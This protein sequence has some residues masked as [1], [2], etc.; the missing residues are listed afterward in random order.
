M[1]AVESVEY[2][3]VENMKTYPL[4]TEKVQVWYYSFVRMQR[5]GS[6]ETNLKYFKG[7]E[8]MKSCD[9]LKFNLDSTSLAELVPGSMD[10][11]NNYKVEGDIKEETLSDCDKTFD[12]KKTNDFSLSMYYEQIDSFLSK[13]PSLFVQDG[14]LG[15]SERSCVHIRSVT[16]DPLVSLVLQSLTVS[17][18][19]TCYSQFPVLDV[20]SKEG[21]EYRNNMT[22]YF[23]KNNNASEQGISGKLVGNHNYQLIVNGNCSMSQLIDV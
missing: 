1:S 23:A 2:E 6:T 15:T 19:Y 18:S 5:V 12:E 17:S 7:S 21:N 4:F 11:N 3:I 16:N 22:I 13:Q 10:A 9:K 20:K 8:W 14:K